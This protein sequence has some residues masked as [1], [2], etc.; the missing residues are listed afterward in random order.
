MGA[1]ESAQRGGDEQQ[2]EAVVDY[3]K[4]LEVAEDATPD[5]I[6]K[7]F[8]RLALIN[9]PDKNHDNIEE[10][11]KKFAVIQQ[12]Y[13]VLSDEQER[14]WYDSHKANLVPE[15]DGDVVF[16]DIRT[17]NKAPRTKD[18]GLT[19]RHLARFFDATIWDGFHDEE[20]GF[21]SI[22]RN[23]FSRIQSEE[24]MLDPDASG[25]PSF[26]YSSWPWTTEM[27]KRTNA[28]GAAREFYSVWSNFAT[29]KEFGW[30]EQWR[31]SEAPDRRVRRFVAFANVICA[32]SCDIL[33]VNWC[34]VFGICRLMEK[35]NKKARDDARREYNETVRALV[36]FLRKR[37]P[38]FKKYEKEQQTLA[39]S[40]S[41]STPTSKQ[42]AQLDL[43][44]YV[45]QDW[46]KVDPAFHKSHADL[47]WGLVEGEN[48]EEEWECVACGKSFRSEA[49]WNSHERS[50]KH[51]R[52]IERLKR[53]MEEDEEEL[54]LQEAMEA[55]A[56]MEMERRAR[57]EEANKEEEE[58]GE[59]QGIRP[60]SPPLSETSEPSD[61]PPSSKPKPKSTPKSTP[62]PQLEDDDVE[63]MPL[64]KTERRALRRAK[65]D[66]LA[67]ESQQ[68]SGTQTPVGDENSEGGGAGATPPPQMKAAALKR[69]KRKQKQTAAGEAESSATQFRCNVCQE[70]FGSKTKLFA[71]IKAEGHAAATAEHPP[72]QN[73]KKGRGKKR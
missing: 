66:A 24:A 37:D 58:E 29:E 48:D 31:L 2:S 39:A 57:E 45:E 68:A 26:G 41:A 14:A 33:M 4:I 27:K 16:E 49:A 50:K 35:D 21:F 5:E 71:H 72:P 62:T 63:M 34:W 25:Y 6:K 46:Q 10:A 43:E 9:H 70:E 8:R 40:Q 42:T 20:N 32:V 61:H 22:Y 64:S 51:L 7:S 1:S 56:E 17:G 67:S 69:A 18:R 55:E 59:E 54:E 47:E 15:A 65:L 28:D 60:S 53:E 23:L 12:A 44:N 11:T 3:Y 38:R 73:G 30:V 52:E 13:E 19:T 36:K